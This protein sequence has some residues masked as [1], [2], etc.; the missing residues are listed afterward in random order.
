MAEMKLSKFKYRL[1]DEQIALHPAENR[2]ESKLMI[3][4]RKKGTLEHR[5]FKDI[6]DY[7]DDKDILVFNDTKV[8]PARLYGNKEK[9]GAEIEVFLLRELNR[10]QR[11]WDVLVDPA[12]KI[13][14]GNKLY[15]GEN[16]LLVAEVIDNTTSRGRTLRFLFDGNYDEFKKT[17]YSLGETPLPK[18]INRPVQPEDKERYQTIFARNEGAVAAPTAG[19]HFSREL[20]K[21]LEIKGIQ[22]AYVTLH[23]GLGNFRSVDVEDLTKHKM[24]SEQIWIY[25][26]A[27]NM[28]N[29]T[30]AER[31]NVCAVGTTVMRTL[32]SSVSTDGY[33]KPFEGWTNKFIFP[34]YEFSVANRMI[35]NFHLPLS[36]LLMM[37]AAFAGYDLLMESYEVALRE[38]YRFGT[39]GDAMLI[40]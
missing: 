7:F 12:R 22:F 6:L 24:D 4:D 11:L 28:I 34:P 17:L 5:R 9:T 40:L 35:T 23:V 31:H 15:F 26:E 14:I 32:E 30:K 1:P 16:D 37:V 38:G 18:F 20:M 33:L 39:Y 13:R 29:R 25:E 3:L 27:C 36:T 21:R 19:L 2:D 10:E 8:F